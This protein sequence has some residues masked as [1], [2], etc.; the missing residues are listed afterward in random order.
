MLSHISSSTLRNKCV[1]T[2]N[3]ALSVVTL[4]MPP[5]S[6]QQMAVDGAFTKMEFGLNVSNLRGMLV[7]HNKRIIA[8]IQKK[9]AWSRINQEQISKKSRFHLL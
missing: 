9:K 6:V 4:D 1:K 5:N 3:R 7:T 2:I 8:L